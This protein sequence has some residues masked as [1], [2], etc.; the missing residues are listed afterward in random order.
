MIASA[1]IRLG[2]STGWFG[3]LRYRYFGPRPLTEDGAFVS[4][5]TGLLNGRL[6]Y[7]FDNGWRIQLD[8]FNLLNSR[9]DQITYA[10][11]SL[12][13]SDSLFA[14]CFP[15]QGAPT[16]PAAVCQTGVMDR[17]LHPVEPLAIRLTLAGQL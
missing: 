9:S 4:A 3:A 15:S 8:G 11:G 12:L 6:G 7:R 17:V 10:Y 14:M 2:E 13:K 16:A 5:A 1:G